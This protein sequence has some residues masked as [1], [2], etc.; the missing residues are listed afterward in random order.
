MEWERFSQG[1]D[2][3]ANKNGKMDKDT[4]REAVM[5][6]QIPTE[7]SERIFYVFNTKHNGLIDKEVPV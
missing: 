1:F 7:L 4:F 5:G 6:F 2:R 3:V